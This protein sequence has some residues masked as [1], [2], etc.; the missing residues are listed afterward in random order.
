MKKFNGFILAVLSIIVISLLITGCTTTNTGATATPTPAPVQK[1]ITV[2]D[3][4]G[5]T[6]TV[7]Y[8]AK[9][10][11]FLVENAMNTM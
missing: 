1:T 4:R 11:V 3:D 2:I 6:L 5:K 9:R 8:L 10:V 7:P